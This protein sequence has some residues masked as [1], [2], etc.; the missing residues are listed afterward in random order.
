MH[1]SKPTPA[2]APPLTCNKKGCLSKGSL[3]YAQN[4]YLAESITLR[5]SP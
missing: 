1:P 4:W 5:G 2:Q 3:S